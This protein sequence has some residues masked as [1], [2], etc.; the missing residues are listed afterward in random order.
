[1]PLVIETEIPVTSLKKARK[2]INNKNT[3]IIVTPPILGIGLEWTLR[4]SGLSQKYFITGDLIRNR[5]IRFEK[6]RAAAKKEVEKSRTVQKFIIKRLSYRK[7]VIY[8]ENIHTVIYL[9][10]K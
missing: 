1:M 2:N 10:L 3:E 9:F 6:T 7:A 5:N 4:I 8:S